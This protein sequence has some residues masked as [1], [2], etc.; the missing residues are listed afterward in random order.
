[1]FVSLRR[2]LNWFKY[3]CSTIFDRVAV[4]KYPKKK[5]KR[6]LYNIFARKTEQYFWGKVTNCVKK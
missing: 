4:M 3:T 2:Y 1:M 6:F 5:I